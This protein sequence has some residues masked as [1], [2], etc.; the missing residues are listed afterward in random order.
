M[1]VKA[2]MKKY[3]NH[4]NNKNIPEKNL[5]KI[6]VEER[7]LWRDDERSMIL[8]IRY[9]NHRGLLFSNQLVFLFSALSLS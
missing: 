6:L 3:S 1:T 2:I 7:N 9:T 4:W 5:G 8:L